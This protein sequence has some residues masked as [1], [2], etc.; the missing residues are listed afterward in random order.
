MKK[1]F[2]LTYTSK[3]KMFDLEEIFQNKF[4]IYFIK[5]S[6]DYLG[7]YYSHEGLFCDQFK[8]LNNKLPDNNYQITDS[9]IVTILKFGFFNGKNKEKQSKY[10]FMKKQLEK[11]NNLSLYSFEVFEN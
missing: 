7:E 10:E 1:S 9:E 11:I 2:F 6:S 3:L 4:D 5:H 8:L